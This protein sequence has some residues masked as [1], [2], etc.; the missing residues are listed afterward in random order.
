MSG[1]TFD[2]RVGQEYAVQRDDGWHIATWDG[3]CF[4]VTSNWQSGD[5]WLPEWVNQH[6]LLPAEPAT[7][8][9]NV[10]EQQEAVHRFERA[11][12]REHRI[13]NVCVGLYALAMAV[14]VL[15]FT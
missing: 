12:R 14:M 5:R 6:I 9:A 4:S 8:R 1:N 3:E 10:S 15:A 7:D 13:A 2:D 11:M